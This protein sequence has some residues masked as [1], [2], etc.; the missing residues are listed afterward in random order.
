MS[1]IDDCLERLKPFGPEF[2]DGLSNYEW[3]SMPF[4]A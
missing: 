1:S 4:R 2:R 3:R